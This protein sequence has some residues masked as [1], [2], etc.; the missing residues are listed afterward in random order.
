MT[1][2]K[3]LIMLCAL[4]GMLYSI[5]MHATDHLTRQKKVLRLHIK[6]LQSKIDNVSKH[7]ALL[8]HQRDILKRELK[9]LNKA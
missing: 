7:K 2:N 1:I 5:S 3:K 6:N 8:Q 9:L 4:A